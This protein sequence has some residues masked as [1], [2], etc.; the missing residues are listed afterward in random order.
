MA[1]YSLSSL[2]GAFDYQAS[3]V[4]FLKGSWNYLVELEQMKSHGSW[5]QISHGEI[6]LYLK[7][8]L[9]VD[10]IFFLRLPIPCHCLFM[11]FKELW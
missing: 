6:I 7:K 4:S 1:E 9:Y 8:K 10:F 3:E 2:M 11:T 5:K